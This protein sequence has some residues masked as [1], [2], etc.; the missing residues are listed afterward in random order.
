MNHGSSVH[1]YKDLPY[2]NFPTFNAKIEKAI[3]EGRSETTKTNT[4]RW[5]SPVLFCRCVIQPILPRPLQ[6]LSTV[7]VGLLNE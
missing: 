7:G 1:D 2:D 4:V 3:A 6:T 5:V